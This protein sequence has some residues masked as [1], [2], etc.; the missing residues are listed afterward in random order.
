MRPRPRNGRAGGHTVQPRVLHA[1]PSWR[2]SNA[3]PLDILAAQRRERA[4]I[5]GERQQRWGHPCPEAA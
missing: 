5:R 2:N 3:R 1:Y 4:H